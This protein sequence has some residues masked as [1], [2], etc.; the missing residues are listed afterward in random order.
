MPGSVFAI[1]YS[2]FQQQHRYYINL[3][4]PRVWGHLSKKQSREEI[5][6]MEMTHCFIAY[7]CIT[8]QPSVNTTHHTVL[9]AWG[10]GAQLGHVPRSAGE[11]PQV[12]LAGIFSGARGKNPLPG[13]FSF[14]GRIWFLATMGICWL[15][16]SQEP[17]SG[18]KGHP[19]PL[20]EGS[21][22]WSRPTTT[23]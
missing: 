7:C 16:V 12:W 19:H 18:S 22:P 2:S 13:P 3:R 6:M 14:V 21:R 20:S 9:Q 10:P 1:S 4:P 23:H 11:P 8:N 5:S 15:A 17:F